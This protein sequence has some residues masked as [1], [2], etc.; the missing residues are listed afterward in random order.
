MYD[1]KY[2][3]YF[4][5]DMRQEVYKSWRISKYMIKRSPLLPQKLRK[6]QNIEHDISKK[7]RHNDKFCAGTDD[8]KRI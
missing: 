7:T 1:K 2:I 8:S 6:K 5:R 3:N 4:N